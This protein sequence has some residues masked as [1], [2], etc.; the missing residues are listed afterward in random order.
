MFFGLVVGG[1]L[2]PQPRAVGGIGLD[3]HSLLYA[4]AAVMLGFQAAIFGVLANAFAVM[5]GL[6]PKSEFVKRV[7]RVVSLE[8]GM[9]FG[10]L[11]MLSGLSAPLPQFWLWRERCFGSLEPQS[12]V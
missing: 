2:L 4:A 10:L 5:Q 11:L 1:W 9:I 12:D 3:V 8:A 6:F 7:Y